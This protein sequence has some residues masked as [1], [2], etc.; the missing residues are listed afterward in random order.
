[1]PPDLIAT[2]TVQCKTVHGDREVQVLSFRRALVPA[3]YACLM[4]YA[5]RVKSLDYYHVSKYPPH[6][7]AR[8]T[9]DV[10]HT[11]QGLRPM[12]EFLPNLQK[13]T[14]VWTMNTVD[15]QEGPGPLALLASPKL[16]DVQMVYT[17]LAEDGTYLPLP[18]SIGEACTDFLSRLSCNPQNVHTFKINFFG[19]AP[20]LRPNLSSLVTKTHSLTSFFCQDVPLTPEGF[21]R[22]TQCSSLQSFTTLIWTE[23][24]T[25]DWKAVLQQLRAQ[26]CF[27]VL[28][29]LELL[30]N[31]IDLC[32]S[33]ID[34]ICSRELESLSL[35]LSGSQLVTGITKCFA[36]LPKW[37]FAPQL[38]ELALTLP[39]SSQPL[40]TIYAADLFPLF[41]LDLHH[42]SLWGFKVAI[43]NE[44]VRKMSEA[45]PNIITLKLSDCRYTKSPYK[46]TLPGLLPFVYN[47]P[48]LKEL[49]LE[50]DATTLA[51][52]HPIPEIRPGFGWEQRALC[53]LHPGYGLISD[54]YFVAGYIADCFPMCWGVISSWPGS[55]DL[56]GPDGTTGGTQGA[57]WDTAWVY[58]RY[59]ARVRAQERHGTVAAG[60]KV[61]EPADPKVVLQYV[62]M[63]QSNPAEAARIASAHGLWAPRASV[64][65]RL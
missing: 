44:L 52:P 35:F 43:S 58:L 7:R 32:I 62:E 18:A 64:S 19:H 9:P 28:R 21:L 48:R 63:L 4:K 1:M 46:V 11:L 16:Q 17:S 57:L 31:D 65:E 27:P 36:T 33:M 50:V 51:F 22:L 56:S 59:F 55:A 60:L 15:E 42:L 29:D 5:V 2:S 20:P 45:W 38:R 54:P 61:R 12:A 40:W 6:V 26:P 41:D 14:W 34:L 3:D 25:E 39:P 49:H 24:W 13:L 37:S 47:C 8:A 53:E 10:W 23:D 30:V